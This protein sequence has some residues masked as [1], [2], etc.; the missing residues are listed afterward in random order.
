MSTQ[1][2]LE[3]RPEAVERVKTR[4]RIIFPLK[5]KSGAETA[6]PRATLRKLQFDVV[7]LLTFQINYAW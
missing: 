6:A 5:H 7:D 4:A 2:N 1:I 3:M